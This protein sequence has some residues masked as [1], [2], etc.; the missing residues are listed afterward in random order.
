ME[1]IG[2]IDDLFEFLES[3]PV[4]FL[5]V[6]TARRR[7]DAAG[8]EALDM[9][10][11]WTLKPGDRRYVVQNGSAIFAFIVGAGAAHSGFHVIASHSDSPGFRIKPHC[12]IACE[13][14]MTKLNTEV[15]GG[16]ILYTWFDRPLSIA[17]RVMLRSADPMRP[18]ART[19]HFRQP[20]LVIPHLA[21][22]FNRA[23][24]EGNKLSKQ[25]DMLPVASLTGGN[26][27]GMIRD[28]VAEYL[29]VSADDIIDYDLSLYSCG[30]P[31][32]AGFDGSMM[33]AGR[34]DDLSM[35]HASLTALLEASATASRHTR[36]A[37]VFDNEETGSGTKQGAGSPILE[38]ILRRIVY[39][40]GGG[41]TDYMRAVADSFLISADNAHGLHPNYVE[42]QDPTV[43]PILGQGPCIKV[44]ANCK[45]MTDADSAAV[46]VELCRRA[47][48]PC[49]YFVNHSDVAGGSTLGNILTSQI[50]LRGVDMG[51]PLWAMHSACETASTDDHV[52]CIKVF[53]QF[54][55]E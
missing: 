55:S 9:R 52:H 22:H 21:I 14:G 51:A 26:A 27:A 25:K 23:V 44:N 1:N 42:K 33:C 17:G 20:L 37:A 48:V 54:F 31:E 49:Q 11:E 7:L 2:Y 5:A 38:H 24:N 50:P 32:I 15:Y 45:Y 29:G 10:D 16:P 6:E 34:L 19:V 30:L 3:S 46:F 43:H 40:L 36:I 28:K 12:E 13:G 18:E 41:E 53:R 4:N 47:G 39:A 8:F 35:V